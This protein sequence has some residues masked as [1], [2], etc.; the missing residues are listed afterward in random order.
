MQVANPAR[1]SILER[2]IMAEIK[3]KMRWEIEPKHLL[4]LGL[5]IG[6]EIGKILKDSNIDILNHKIERSTIECD[7]EFTLR[8]ELHEVIAGLAGINIAI[9]WNL[10]HF[11][12]TYSNQSYKLIAFEND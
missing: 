6:T 12:G 7:V 9:G 4:Q 2:K 8:G 11:A 3:C 5:S 1:R 10:A